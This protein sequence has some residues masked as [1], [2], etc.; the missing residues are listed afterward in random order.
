MKLEP[1]AFLERAGQVPVIDV[2]SPAEFK[3]GHIP[4]AFNIPLF[5]NEERTIVGTLYKQSG[6][7]AA[8]L[9]GLDITGPKMSSQL[10]QALAIAKNGHLLV[11]CW[12]GGMR[13]QS[14]AWLFEQGGLH[15]D[16]L[17]GGYKAYRR[18][19]RTCLEK[20]DIPM[21]VLGGMTGSGKTEILSYLKKNGSQVLD[22][23]GLAHHKGSAFGHI[24][25]TPQPTSEQFENDL[26]E[27]RM[28]LNPQLPVWVE[29]ESRTIGTVSIPE[30]VFAKMRQAI[31]ISIELPVAERVKRLVRE[32][33]DFPSSLLESAIHRIRKKLGGQHAKIAVESL[34]KGDF[35]R[36]AEITLTYYDKAYRKGLGN[37]DPKQVF[38]LKLTEDRP[39]ENALK[40]LD[41]Y[42][43]Q[44]IPNI[45]YGA[46][47]S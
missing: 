23:E 32:Y 31:T 35:E 38:T 26:A 6:R 33:A 15:T 22:L 28:Q 12:R 14:M 2:R 7:Q 24:G 39:E 1:G 25:Q 9:R 27:I 43:E 13:S 42:H 19:I 10:K 17:T 34:L 30:P 47:I 41:F 18:H 45:S 21:V 46:Y 20:E 37:R 5:D 3:Q 29:D 4:S 40:I 8:I 16:T 44:V 11:H 36:V